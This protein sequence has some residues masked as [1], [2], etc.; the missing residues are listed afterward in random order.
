MVIW[1]RDSI[2][3]QIVRPFRR[4]NWF[5]FFLSY[6]KIWTKIQMKVT[7]IFG[8]NMVN[9]VDTELAIVNFNLHYTNYLNSIF[10]IF[11]HSFIRMEINIYLLKKFSVFLICISFSVGVRPCTEKIFSASIDFNWIYN[12]IVNVSSIKQISNYIKY[13]VETFRSVWKRS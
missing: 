1:Q 6:Q 10:V 8:I 7:F 3:H 5:S 12:G 11:F 13:K 2:Y 9:L 4:Q